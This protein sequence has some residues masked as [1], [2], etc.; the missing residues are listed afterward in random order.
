MRSSEMQGVLNMAAGQIQA[1]AGDGYEIESAHPI[2]FVAIASV[3]TADY[4][5]ILDNNRNNTLLKS[6]GSVKI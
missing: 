5:A 1:H 2:S 3:R 4:K 6:A